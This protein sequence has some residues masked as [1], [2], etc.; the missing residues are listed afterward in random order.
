MSPALRKPF[1]FLCL[2]F[3]TFLPLAGGW[4]K[5]DGLPPMYGEFPAQAVL[6]PPPAFN[7]WYY[8]AGVATVAVMVAFLLF[9]RLFGFKAPAETPRVQW[10]PLPGWFWPAVVVMV[11]SWLLM[12][13]APPLAARFTFVPLWW[14]LIY[15]LDGLVYALAGGRSLVS[16]R[17]HEMLILALVSVVG[18]F[19]YEYWNYFVLSN[20]YYPYAHL[21]TPF[22]NIVWF[23]LS[24]TT[25]WPVCFEMFMLL[26]ALPAFRLR[27]A[28]G[29][30]VAVPTAVVAA[31]LVVG[32]A[33]Q[34][35]IGVF[36]YELF[37]GLWIGSLLIFGCALVLAGCWTPFTPAAQGD[38]SRFVLMAL[39]TF[40]VG[41]VWEFWNYGS[42][43]WRD[44]PVNPNYWIYDVP[45]FN[46][47][48][49]P[50]SEMPALGYFGYLAFGMI[51]W[52]YWLMIA[53]LLDLDP[54]F[55]H[56]DVLGGQ[57]ALSEDRGEQDGWEAA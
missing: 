26:M 36:P 16:V 40:F 15:A 55:A 2:L 19:L 10:G 34:F 27:W 53:H 31:F 37:W 23:S 44:A 56:D 28:D 42:Q 49:L 8:V 45:Y 41:F 22:G 6:P 12:W 57:Q 43:A 7:F 9:P 5:W 35:L 14:G 3:A 48:H 25:V 39:G 33:L 17:K 1:L 52:V 24:Y 51:V 46:V 13:F 30:K 21:L 4:L 47:H 50:F 54:D 11:A 18:W 32:L 29:P 38:W 20:W